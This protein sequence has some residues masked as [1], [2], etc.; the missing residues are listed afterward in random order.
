MTDPLRLDRSSRVLLSGRAG[1][2][3][4][5]DRDARPPRRRP[6]LS[7]GFD[8][9]GLQLGLAALRVRESEGVHS[10]GA[11][12]FGDGCRD[13]FNPLRHFRKLPIH[14]T[15]AVRWGLADATEDHRNPRRHAGGDPGSGGGLSHHR[16]SG[17]HARRA[18]AD[19][20]RLRRP[21]A[22]PLD[23][24]GSLAGRRA[25]GA[26]REHARR[27]ARMG[28]PR[29]ARALAARATAS[30]TSGCKTISTPTRSQKGRG[31]P[32]PG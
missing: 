28:Q 21:G 4:A 19:G 24:D 11:H 32:A 1:P 10:A 26:G 27:S 13:P 6:A 14:G 22:A 12:K 31:S 15:Q 17:D 16:L 3:L 8:F 9:A 7:E 29:P 5:A 18:P 25:M 30:A 23:L 20:R 2:G